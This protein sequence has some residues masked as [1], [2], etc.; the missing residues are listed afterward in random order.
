[1]TKTNPHSHFYLYSKGWYVK[2]NT[3]EDLRTLS[4]HYSGSTYCSDNDIFAILMDA[5]YPEIKTSYQFSR[6]V[7]DVSRLGAFEA[8]V[9]FMS[10]VPIGDKTRL[11]V[12]KPN[13]K[14]LPMTDENVYISN[15]P[16]YDFVEK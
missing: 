1:M 16:E 7:S 11:P 5:I 8:C 4:R 9:N 3:L 10:G 12:E 13:P 14:I 2:N 15:D 6:F